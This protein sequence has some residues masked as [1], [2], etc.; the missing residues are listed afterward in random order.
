MDFNE[1]RVVVSVKVPRT[2]MIISLNIEVVHD[3]M[4][5][6]PSR[7]CNLRSL[8]IS[9]STRSSA[10]SN[11]FFENRPPTS[12]FHTLILTKMIQLER[13]TPSLM[14]EMKQRDSSH[15]CDGDSGQF[16]S[17][18]GGCVVSVSSR[19]VSKAPVWCHHPPIL[20][21]L[22]QKAANAA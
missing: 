1:R 14:L 3:C 13:L 9:Y 12:P 6:T 16:D 19:S 18:R 20:V 17:V 7:H 4:V 22:S 11:V 15:P 8:L 21:L 5:D 2:R 10:K